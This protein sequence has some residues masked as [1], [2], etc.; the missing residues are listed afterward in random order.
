MSHLDRF[1]KLSDAQYHAMLQPPSAPVRCVIDTDTR[2]EIDDQFAL[3]WALLS[4]DQL[5]IE[6]IYAAPYSFQARMRNIRQADRIRR[7]ES[8]ATADERDLLAKSH[9][10]AAALRRLGH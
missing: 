10:A 9:R 4:R 6:A 7:R 8:E 3:A 1:P 5:Q 2:N